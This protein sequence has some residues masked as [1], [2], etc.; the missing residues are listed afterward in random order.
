MGLF[1]ATLKQANNM[2]EQLHRHHKCVQG[3]RFSIGYK[4]ED[5]KILGIA[6]VGRPVA[7]E[8]DQYNVAEITRLVTDSSRNVCSILYSA[9]ARAAKAMGYKWI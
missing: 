9:C 3:H 6:V 4:D 2:I 8:V 5:G 7:R 1:P